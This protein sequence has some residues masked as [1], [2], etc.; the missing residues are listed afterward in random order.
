MRTV[1]PLAL[2]LACV[3]FAGCHPREARP[4]PQ[5]S[6]EPFSYEPAGN[7]PP[8]DWIPSLNEARARAAEDHKPLLVFVRAAWA[9]PSVDMDQTVWSDARVLA[10]VPRFIALRVDLTSSY[11]K[12]IPSTLSDFNVETVPTTVIVGS[13]G[14][15]AARFGAG[16]ASAVLV[17][18]AM[19]AA[20]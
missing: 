12:S 7:Y 4:L 14:R 10:E 8:V 19:K 6:P 20:R 15:I 11:G 9:K 2:A 13:D 5:G 1:A 3:A 17:A 18:A 16:D